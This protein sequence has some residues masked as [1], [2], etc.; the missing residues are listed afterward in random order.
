M[1][2]AYLEGFKR[3]EQALR[4]EDSYISF[5][6]SQL[7]SFLNYGS[8][9]SEVEPLMR[10]ALTIDERS[11]GI[12]H[13][14]VA[15]D[16]SNLAQLLQATNRL[17]EAEPLMRRA[18]AIDE[19]SYGKDHPSVATALNN[20]AT[21]L[22]AADQLA[23]AEPLMRRHVE[24]FLKFTRTAGHPHPHLQD[25]ASNCAFLLQAMGHSPDEIQAT[26][27]RMAPDLFGD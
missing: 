16:L 20:L 23:E 22:L 25:A 15:V 19:R 21:L 26:L 5:A 13:P 27:R 11:Y 18:L 3:W 12:D 2:E 1:G 7:A 9:Y 6:A 8:L 17:A 14:R 24:I 10:H 4:R